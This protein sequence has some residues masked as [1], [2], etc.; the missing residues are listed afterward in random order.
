MS[1]ISLGCLETQ[2]GRTARTLHFKQQVQVFVVV[3][4]VDSCSC[5]KSNMTPSSLRA[6]STTQSLQRM[7]QIR[8]FVI[9]Y[10]LQRRKISTRRGTEMGFPTLL[11]I[12][13]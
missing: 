1:C 9:F 7:R 12:C 3:K 10:R 6:S 8:T 2:E 13:S 4:C 5:S 11:L